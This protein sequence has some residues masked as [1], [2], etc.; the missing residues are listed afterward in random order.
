MGILVASP[1]PAPPPPPAVPWPG[2]ASMTW[3]VPDLVPEGDDVAAHA[4]HLLRPDSHGLMLVQDGVRGLGMPQVQRWAST[5]PAVHGSAWRGFRVEERE[6]YW[7][8]LVWSDAGTDAWLGRDRAL[9]AGMRP[10]LVG[11]WDVATPSG[12]RRL[13]LRWTET[14][15]QFARDPLRSG[16]HVYGITLVAEQPFWEGATSTIQW[17]SGA[18]VPFLPGPPFTMSGSRSLN[19][20]TLDN[21]GDVPLWPVWRIHGPC[22]TARVGVA[23]AVIE[24]PF[25]VP[26]GQTLVIDTSP[27]AQT[28]TMYPTGR[29]SGNGLD[30]T[31]LLGAAAFAPVPPAGRVVLSLAA[32]GGGSVECS[33]TPR[34][35]RAW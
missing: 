25:A 33:V 32:A 2:V 34:Y 8:L 12:W 29:Y 23:G 6:V 21:P 1:R 9:W 24:V 11:W 18:G 3:T 15:A 4:L 7:P 5:A 27:E 13:R 28:A 20:A 30:R 19:D 22:S 16:W 31:G 10:D 14:D 17:S 26:A 35:Y